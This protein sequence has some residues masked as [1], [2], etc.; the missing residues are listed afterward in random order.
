M[1]VRLKADY[2]GAE[3]TGNSVSALNLL[4]LAWITGKEEWRKRA[5]ATIEAFGGRLNDYPPILPQMLVAHDFQ[6]SKPRQFVVVGKLGRPDTEIMLAM[7]R[8]RFLPGKIV[9]LADGGVRA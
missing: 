9:L 4:R 3:P 8:K 5:G 1:L 2:D 6:G 7:I